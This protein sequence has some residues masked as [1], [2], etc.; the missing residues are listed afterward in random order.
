MP[1]IDEHTPLIAV[2]QV[3]PPTR[4]YPHHTFRRFCTFTLSIDH[5]AITYVAG[6]QRRT[7]GFGYKEALHTEASVLQGPQPKPRL[8]VG[9][10]G[11]TR[12]NRANICRQCN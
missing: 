5:T 3:G 2:V 8:V 6:L 11:N 4:R 9:T 12:R 10:V 7:V 1:H